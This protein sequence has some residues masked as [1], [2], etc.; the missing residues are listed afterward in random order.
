MP[1]ITS[2][3]KL[4]NFPGAMTED[5]LAFEEL[6][7]QMIGDD[8][9]VAA[10]TLDSTDLATL[11][12]HATWDAALAAYFSVL[13]EL[14]EK[15]GKSDS[16]VTKLKTRN[17]VVSGRRDSSHEIYIVGI[18]QLQKQYLEST[19][20]SAAT[21]C[22]VLRNREKDSI[23]ILNGMK[24]IAEW[25]GE[26]DGLWAVTLSSSFVGTSNDKVILITGI[27]PDATP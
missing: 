15:A 5:D 16:K 4:D 18:S 9:Y 17:Y 11:V 6:M 23:I 12:D 27:V 3:E 7:A 22:I 20:F 14:A 8:V 26:T 19:A 13:G 25:S 1:P 2:V 24:W 21:L 10:G